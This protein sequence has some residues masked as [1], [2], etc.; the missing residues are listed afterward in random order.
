MGNSLA[1]ES[2]GQLTEESSSSLKA[3][4]GQNNI[5]NGTFVDQ[6]STLNH[7]NLRILSLDGGGVK[8]L[9]PLLIL[10]EIE[11]LTGKKVFKSLIILVFFLNNFVDL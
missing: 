1:Q 11:R 3:N 5:N 6:H 4:Q 9:V 7:S 10:I 2:I 8:G